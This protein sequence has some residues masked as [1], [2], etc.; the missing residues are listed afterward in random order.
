MWANAIKIL[1]MRKPFAAISSYISKKS[2]SRASIHYFF[3]TH[4]TQQHN[5]AS[6]YL[7]GTFK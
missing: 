4:P 5:G 1:P 6:N 7:K 3:I 2:Y